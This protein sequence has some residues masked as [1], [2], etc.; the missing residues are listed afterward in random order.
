MPLGIRIIDENCTGCTLCVK[1]CPFAAVKV[2]DKIAVINEACTLC[3]SCVPA[4]KFDAIELIRPKRDDIDTSEF[5]GVWVVAET[6][7]P[8]LKKVSLELTSEARKIADTLGQEVGVVLLGQGVAGLADELA[9]QGADKVYLAEGENLKE[10]STSTYAGVL[11]GMITTHKPNIVL[12]PVYI[13]LS[14]GKTRS[15]PNR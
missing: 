10:Y 14:L 11:T 6:R 5:K 4:C 12:L 2:I 1:A 13:L 15:T 3:G 9:A 8:K 7:G